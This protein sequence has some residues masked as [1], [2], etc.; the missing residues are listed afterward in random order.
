MYID[1]TFKPRT[2][3]QESY[4]PFQYKR[5]NIENHFDDGY[6]LEWMIENLP[7]DEFYI[8]DVFKQTYEKRFPAY[9]LRKEDKKAHLKSRSTDS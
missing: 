8:R 2:K 3:A 4:L 7:Y 9:K 5:A 6:S 1:T